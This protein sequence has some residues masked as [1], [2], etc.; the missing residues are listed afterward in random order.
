MKEQSDNGKDKS[1]T[2]GMYLQFIVGSQEYMYIP[3]SK[4]AE[5]SMAGVGVP[6]AILIHLIKN[7]N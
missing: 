5:P 2:R 1:E 4:P 3:A 6:R 7:K